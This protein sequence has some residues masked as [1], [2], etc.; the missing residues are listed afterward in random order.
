V[1][2]LLKPAQIV[3]GSA[4]L[5]PICLVQGLSHK[6]FWIVKDAARSALYETRSMELG[7]GSGE[8]STL[9]LRPAVTD[10]NL[11]ASAVPRIFHPLKPAAMGSSFARFK[12][13]GRFVNT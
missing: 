10:A 7:D 4:H 1:P 11:A 12:S 6:R 2:Q 5:P 9:G 3:P 8:L 13:L